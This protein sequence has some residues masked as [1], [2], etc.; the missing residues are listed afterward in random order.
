MKQVQHYLNI[1]YYLKKYLG[2]LAEPALNPGTKKPI[3]PEEL[4]AIFPM[5]LIRQ[6]AS[7]EEFVEIPDEVQE[8]YQKYRQTPLVRARGLEKYLKTPARIYYK[9]ESVTLSGSHKINTAIPQA[10]YN[11]KEGIKRLATE[12]GAGQWGSALS[13][14]CSLFGLE[15]LVFMVKVSF[16]QKP[17]RQTIMRFFGAKV[18]ASPS[19]TTQAGKRFL[20]KNPKT[21][22]SLGMA[23]SEAIEV[24]A[25]DKIT[26][27]SLGSVLNFVLLHQTVVGQEVKQQLKDIGEKPNV[28]IGC[29]GG[30]SNFGGFAFPLLADQLAGKVR[31]IRFIGVE[32]L[33]CPSMTKGEYRYDFGDSGQMTPLLKMETLGCDFVPSPIHAGGLRYHG[34]APIL[35]FLHQKGLMEARAYDQLSVFKAAQI[36]AKTEGIIPAPETSHAIKAVIDEALR[37]K[38][39]KKE[40]AII[41]NFSGHGLLDLKGY[42]DFLGGKLK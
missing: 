5:E 26:N 13:I 24:A 7:L 15:C 19:T 42:E 40:E 41:F 1:N 12:T 30:G 21:T 3:K 34:M 32:P 11:Q 14:A 9:N 38:R 35:S 37:C 8:I 39:Q 29:C 33:A 28:V 6:E 23:I 2:E 4:A 16:E 18:L 36:F 10:Y 27:Y 25:Q 31:G 22:G 17:Q 20:A